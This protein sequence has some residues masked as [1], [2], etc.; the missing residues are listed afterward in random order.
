MNSVVLPRGCLIPDVREI[1]VGREG[2]DYG[3]IV[4]RRLNGGIPGQ[5]GRRRGT[6]R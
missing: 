6:R 3:R 4:R 2:V 1:S 5:L